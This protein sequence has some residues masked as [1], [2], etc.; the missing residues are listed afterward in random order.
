M[1]FKL[2][3]RKAGTTPI[4]MIF[5]DVT[6]G[7][8]G[9]I[10]VK[11]ESMLKASSEKVAIDLSKTTFID[12]HGLGVFVF[13]FRRLSDENRQLI[14]LKPSEFIKDLFSGSNLDKIFTILDDEET[15]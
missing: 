14:F 4:L 3:L 5:G 11:L 13:F 15:L 12:S 8:V 2:R 7:N 9:K 10:T 6:G 1:N